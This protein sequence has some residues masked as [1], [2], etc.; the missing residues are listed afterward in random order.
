LSDL[1]GTKEVYA[2]SREMRGLA[3]RPESLDLLFR[4]QVRYSVRAALLAFYSM[5]AFLI[6][7]NRGYFFRKA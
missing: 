7:R 6:W 3:V 5:I 1:E 2:E 4:P